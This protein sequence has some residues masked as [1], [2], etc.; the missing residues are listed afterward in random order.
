MRIVLHAGLHKSATTLTQSFWG[1]VWD[2]PGPTW[3]P[4]RAGQ[5][6]GHSY[7]F[8]PYLRAFTERDDPDLVLVS[9]STHANG[10]ALPRVVARAEQQGVETL[11]L[12]S[13]DLD[14]VQPV[15]VPGV[16]AALGPHELTVLITATRPVHR[17]CANWQTLVR[18]GLDENPKGSARVI[19]RIAAL[20]PGRLETLARTWPASRVVVRLVETE[21]AEPDLPRDLAQTLGLPEIGATPATLSR[22][23]SL[24]TDIEVLRRINGA[25]QGLGMSRG[26]AQRLNELRGDGFTYRSREGSDDEFVL[27]E[28]AWEAARVEQQFLSRLPAGPAMTLHDPRELLSRWLEPELPDWYATIRRRE[29]IVPEL[30]P[31]P[32]RS[33]QLWRMRQERAAY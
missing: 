5:S 32:D 17:W 28:T 30:D 19:E 29:A 20:T 14:R 27:T 24:G 7:L 12:S 31:L 6:P 11:V 4:K 15:D 21:P 25:D 33:E 3:Y 26:G 2:E 1:Q 23:A 13:E 9:L 10:D 16:V 8:R 18:R 22:N